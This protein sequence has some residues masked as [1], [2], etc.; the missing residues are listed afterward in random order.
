MSR[1]NKNF[2]TGFRILRSCLLMWWKGATFEKH[3]DEGV[4]CRTRHSIER[5]IQALPRS[6]E[7]AGRG[8]RSEWQDECLSQGKKP[9]DC[10]RSCKGPLRPGLSMTLE[11]VQFH[12]H[13][14]QLNHFAQND[15][16]EPAW[17]LAQP[18]FRVAISMCVCEGKTVF[19]CR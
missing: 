4:F 12:H 7:S 2:S 15:I 16:I 19:L 14:T 11:G 5:R 3:S 13:A 10:G 17:V 6:L 8:H 1:Q 18:S 9:S